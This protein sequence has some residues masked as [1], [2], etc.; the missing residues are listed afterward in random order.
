MTASATVRAWRFAST[1]Q[2]PASAPR[3]ATAANATA[4]PSRS[5]SAPVRH[6]WL[7]RDSTIGRIGAMHG[8]TMVNTPAR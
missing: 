4:S 2:P 6:G 5:G 7:A 8:V 1:A 3:L